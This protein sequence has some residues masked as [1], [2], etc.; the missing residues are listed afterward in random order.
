MG[1][2]LFDIRR[3]EGRTAVLRFAALLLVVITGHTILEAARDALLLAGPGPRALGIVYMTIAVMAWPAAA[4]A[5]RANER[6]GARGALAG[7]LLLAA[8]LCVGLLLGGPG[9]LVSIAVY[10]VSGL[11][12][13]I[14]I[15]Q[16]WMYV[17]QALTL[18]QGRRLFGV[19]AA[20]GVLGG[21][22]GSGLAAAALLVLPVRALIL[23]SAGMFV[24][25]VVAV[26]R[27]QDVGRS[28]TVTRRAPPAALESWSAVRREPLVTRIAISI[29]VST[30]ALLALDYCFKSAVARSLPS[31]SIGPFVARYY[32]VLNGLSL[33]V[34]LFLASAIVQRMGV[35]KAI[36]LT[37]LLLG[38]GA[39]GV[40]LGGGAMLPVLLLKG[41]DGALRFS[42]HRITGEL[43]Y[44]PV[45]VLVRRRLKPF[46]DGAL[47][48]ASQTATGLVL[49][50]LGGTW[51]LAPR[52][53]AAV[54]ALL[55]AGWFGVVVTMRRPYLSML[56]SAISSRSLDEQDSPEPLD[57]ESA[58]LLVQHL[59]SEDPREV[60]GVMN[61]LCR[62]GQVG[63]LSALVLLHPDETVLAQALEHFG[64]SNRVDWVPM[65]LRLLA[66]SRERVR[67]ASARA[68]SMHGSLDP[69]RL[70][71]DASPRVRGYAAVAV[72]LRDGAEDALEQSSIATL[73][74]SHD[75]D[76]A[77]RARLGMLAA[78]ADARPA[79][80]LSRLLLAL[81]D[82]SNDGVEYTELL[83]RAA[84]KQ[85][86]A[87]LIPR[88][89]D[90]LGSREGREAIRA[91]LVAFGD[92]ALESVRWAL[93]DTS[94]P[95][96]FRIH[97]PKTLARFGT[98]RAA[99]HLLE[100]VETEEDGLVRYKSIRAL[101][102]LVSS[103]RVTV[104]RA[105]VERIAYADLLRHFHV[106]ACRFA[107]DPAPPQAAGRPAE[108]L[109][110]GL[111][112]DK[113]RQS[114]ER[115]FRLLAIAHPRDDFDRL[116]IATLSGDPFAR[117]SADELLDAL[118]R[119]HDQQALRLLLRIVAD[120]LP[121]AERLARAAPLVHRNWPATR[122]EALAQL[123]RDRDPTVLALAVACAKPPV[124]SG[125]RR[126][127][128]ARLGGPFRA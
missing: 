89:V 34:Q 92:E 57:L 122:G 121:R 61:A 37:P 126:A 94:R 99:D 30:A 77:I 16:F 66:D 15:P 48:R 63:F 75:A 125:R 82:E 19:I 124:A 108:R 105:R 60:V 95:R 49:L 27:M 103:G 45:P 29:A 72:A 86:D 123:E 101:E 112:E 33:A 70:A 114:L 11:I 26:S 83:A 119:R 21:V 42:L 128:D 67:L 20:A 8:A 84:G 98:K 104:D 74:A 76:A 97:V 90:R 31:A 73:L 100:N 56:R 43:V 25:A 71:A 110:A 93:R 38:L 88:L 50:A 115:V 111:L 117:A 102:W 106:L 54:V 85:R 35:T 51:V 107:L 32:L 59:A 13:S 58:Q 40:F 10:V 96:R 24:V 36:V 79:R 69:E 17:G 41:V 64:A 80:S 23:L 91:S 44:L 120:D 127:A 7:T 65:A 47:A 81:G 87:R 6:F 5:S 53:L 68:L 62:R 9:P 22:T 3:G 113:L 39:V 118:L 1:I 46:I 116:R 18:A 109:L 52:P 78:I 28:A 4:L 14:A 2:R 55:A 12:G